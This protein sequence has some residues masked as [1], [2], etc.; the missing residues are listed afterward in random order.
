MDQEFEKFA[1]LF[2]KMQIIIL[3]ADAIT[4]IS[5]YGMLLKDIV[6]NKRTLEDCKTIALTESSDTTTEMALGGGK[7]EK[8]DEEETPLPPSPQED[9]V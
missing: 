8:N 1:N 2:K 5:S 9:K 4:Q 6:D 3:M 7:N